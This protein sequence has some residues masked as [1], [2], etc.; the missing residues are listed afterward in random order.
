MHTGFSV[1]PR[2]KFQGHPALA[3]LEILLVSSFQLFSIFLKEPRAGTYKE[4]G[5][6]SF[7]SRLNSCWTSLSL[8]LFCPY[9]F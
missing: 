5:P 8:P 3:L 7:I 4:E 1:V 9:I 6:N 2:E